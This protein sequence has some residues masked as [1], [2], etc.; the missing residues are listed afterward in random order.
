[1]DWIPSFTYLLGRM[2]LLD[3]HAKEDWGKGTLTIGRGS[4]KVTLPWFPTQYHG[5]TR[6]NGTGFTKDDGYET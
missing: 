4:K 3:A 6:N 2:W 5:E 1:M